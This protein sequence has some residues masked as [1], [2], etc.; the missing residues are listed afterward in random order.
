M[1]QYKFK[2]RFNNLWNY[3]TKTL[4]ALTVIVLTFAIIHSYITM[5]SSLNYRIIHLQESILK[6]DKAQISYDEV[7]SEAN[8]IAENSEDPEYCLVRIDSVLSL[9]KSNRKIIGQSD[10]LASNIIDIL[11]ENLKQDCK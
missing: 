10:K 7:I 4:I 8:I 2:F 3:Y 9:L 6:W 1:R 11:G 5:K